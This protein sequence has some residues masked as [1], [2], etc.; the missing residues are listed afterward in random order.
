MKNSRFDILSQRVSSLPP[1]DTAI[2]DPS[3]KEA[4]AGAVMA[5]GKGFI[6]PIILGNKIGILK[7]ADELQMAIDG[8]QIIDLDTKSAIEYG[9]KLARNGEVKAIVKGNIHTD[10]LMSEVVH[11]E[12]GLRTAA[13]MSHCFAVDVPAYKKLFIITDAALNVTPNLNEKK[14]IVQNAIILAQALGI[15][16]PKVALLSAVEIVNENIPA[17]LECAIL[18]KMSERNQIHGGVLDGPLSLDLAISSESAAV[19]NLTSEVTGN[20][21]VLVVPNLESGNI[22]FKA[23][24]YLANAMSFGLVLGA[25]VPI[26]LTSRSATAQSRSGSCL[27]AKIVHYHNSNLTKK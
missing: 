15:V 24:N 22:L 16:M 9:V 4:L 6:N 13:R 25:K 27:L 18:C 21:D 2:I 19:K 23:L 17:T 20:A 7:L 26:V 3:S 5:A 8:Y 10:S 12:R 11:A 1:I 14:H